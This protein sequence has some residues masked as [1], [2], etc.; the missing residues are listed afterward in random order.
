[1][2][3]NDKYI[4]DIPSAKDR[5]LIKYYFQQYDENVVPKISKLRKSIIHGDVNEW[6]V[7]VKNNDVTG[8]IDFGDLCYTP[9]INELA[10]T[11]AYACLYVENPLEWTSTIIESYNK[12]LTLEEKELA[13]LYYLIAARL[14]ISV[15]NSAYERVKNPTNTYTAI[16]EKLAWQFLY[17]WLK[18]NPIEA[19]NSFRKTIGFS[20][21][22]TVTTDN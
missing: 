17:N 4:K 2:H 22:K 19:E 6:N 13:A 10:I 12:I 15:C 21:M 20:T 1:M 5:N 9:L 16:S 8:I 3:F 11:I 18:I 14:C 7:L